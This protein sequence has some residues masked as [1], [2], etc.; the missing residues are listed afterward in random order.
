MKA[1]K[2][3]EEPK[4]ATGYKVPD[5]YFDAFQSKV[6]QRLNESETPV[7][8]LFARRKTWVMA[9]AAVFILALSIPLVQYLNSTSTEIDKGSLENYLAN[10]ADISEDEIVELLDENDIQKIKVDLKIEDRELEDILTA[11][12]NIEDYIVD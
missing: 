11:D 7:V 8:S 6:N 5:A 3:D 1:F 10:H 4:I 9:V 12:N 2:L